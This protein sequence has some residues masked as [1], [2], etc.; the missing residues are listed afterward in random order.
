MST[1][2]LRLITE[3]RY[4]ALLS[5]SLFMLG[6]VTRTFIIQSKCRAEAFERSESYFTCVHDKTARLRFGGSFDFAR[7]T[8]VLYTYYVVGS[9]IVN[10]IAL[11]WCASAPRWKRAALVDEHD[12]G[13]SSSS[14][15]SPAHRGS[16][17]LSDLA[18]CYRLNRNYFTPTMKR[19]RAINEFAFVFMLACFVY[20]QGHLDANNIFLLNSNLLFDVSPVALPWVVLVCIALAHLHASKAL[21]AEQAKLA[22]IED[23]A[24]QPLSSLLSSAP[25]L[26]VDSFASK[27]FQLLRENAGLARSLEEKHQRLME[28]QDAKAKAELAKRRS[29]EELQFISTVNTELTSKYESLRETA[30]EKFPIADQ[31]EQMPQFSTMIKSRVSEHKA[32]GKTPRKSGR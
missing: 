30:D 29:Q 23:G 10:A 27:L 26:L 1:I 22:T 8:D 9:F 18:L 13:G 5:L 14:S 15:S 25:G 16:P 3:S 4:N 7:Q 6:K 31:V 17:P 11:V 24:E 21:L 2:L 12:D 32:R 28:E 20:F 19:L